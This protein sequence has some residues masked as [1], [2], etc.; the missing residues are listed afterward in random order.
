MGDERKRARDME[1]F[2][3]DKEEGNGGWAMSEEGRQ[4]IKQMKRERRSEGSG[5]LLWA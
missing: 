1:R 2:M 5:R 3:S 4:A